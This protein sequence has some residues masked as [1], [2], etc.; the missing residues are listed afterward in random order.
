MPRYLVIT[1]NVKKEHLTTRTYKWHIIDSSPMSVCS[2]ATLILEYYHNTFISDSDTLD[3]VSQSSINWL[4][5]GQALQRA[6]QWT[7]ARDGSGGKLEFT[8][9]N[10]ELLHTILQFVEGF[11]S[12]SPEEAKLVFKKPF[13][14]KTSLLP[15]HFSSGA[16]VEK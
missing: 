11:S 7:S 5:M 6:A 1:W 10:E 2:L 14:W 3:H 8:P 16:Y 4:T 15:S 9:T 12:K 13:T